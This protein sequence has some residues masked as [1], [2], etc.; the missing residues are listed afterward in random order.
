MNQETPDT[1]FDDLAVTSLADLEPQ[2]PTEEVDHSVD[3]QFKFR[4][5][6]LK[7]AA[8]QIRNATAGVP[9]QLAELVQIS[10]R[11]NLPA[12]LTAH[13]Q[14]TAVQ[15]TAA[16][17][18][19]DVAVDFVFH[20]NHLSE[21]AKLLSDVEILC[22]LNK[23]KRY[24]KVSEGG[25]HQGT[26]FPL[27]DEKDFSTPD[28]FPGNSENARSFP[29]AEFLFPFKF[30][31]L[32]LDK[33]DI[34]KESSVVDLDAGVMF[35]ESGQSYVIAQVEALKEFNLV[36]K[37]DAVNPLDKA[38]AQMDKADVRMTETATY[39]LFQ[40]MATV[41]GAEKTTHTVKSKEQALA[42]KGSH[43]IVVPREYLKRQIALITMSLGQKET[44]IY[45]TLKGSSSDAKLNFLSKDTGDRPNKS[46]CQAN[47][48]T[49]GD[50]EV[51]VRITVGLIQ[52]AIAYFETPNVTLEIEPDRFLILRDGDTQKGV[53]VSTIIPIIR[54]G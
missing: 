32:F 18:D 12:T 33:D 47:R 22:T 8:L 10:L 16:T 27:S 1:S 45:I 50:A 21:I 38:L 14:T 46:L 39:F 51:T 9:S 36:I 30:M 29:V 23:K 44:P 2:A 41:V 20:I 34:T 31:G 15:T 17:E 6:A 42:V 54:E 5:G 43:H 52:R 11:P 48:I 4:P 25:T 24:L 3:I 40:D 37:H 7:G 19:V 53:Q 13:T 35:V 49:E 28:G 26:H